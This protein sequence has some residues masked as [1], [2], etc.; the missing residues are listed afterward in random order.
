MK[1]IVK[2]IAGLT[3]V[4]F[5]I[6]SNFITISMLD[7]DRIRS[8]GIMHEVSLI[9]GGFSILHHLGM[10]SIVCGFFLIIWSVLSEHISK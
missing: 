4:L 9:G 10:I 7:I 1:N 6:F 8:Y 3:C 2:V 5:G